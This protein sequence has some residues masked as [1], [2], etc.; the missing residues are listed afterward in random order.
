MP[1][2]LEVIEQELTEEESRVKVALELVKLAGIPMSSIG[3]HDPDA[4]VAEEVRSRDATL[5]L[6]LGDQTGFA[7]VRQDLLEKAGG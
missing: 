6:C 7:Q 5:L 1:R 3:P 4:I 2:A